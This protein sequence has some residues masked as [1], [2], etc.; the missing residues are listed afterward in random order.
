MSIQLIAWSLCWFSVLS[1]DVSDFIIMIVLFISRRRRFFHRFHY[2]LH[3][4]CQRPSITNCSY[5]VNEKI[6]L[7]TFQQTCPVTSTHTSHLYCS[8]FFLVYASSSLY[9]STQQSRRYRIVPRSSLHNIDARY[10]I[11]RLWRA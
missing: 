5:W 11:Y 10:S 6:K 1:A 3:C 2:S 8:F 7:H 9:S 4:F